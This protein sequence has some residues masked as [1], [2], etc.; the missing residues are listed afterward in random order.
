MEPSDLYARLEQII[1]DTFCLDAASIGPE[2]T[3]L[4]IDGWDSLSHLILMMNIEKSFGIKF[5]LEAV[6]SMRNVGD[7]VQLIS[8]IASGMAT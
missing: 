4:D 1:S 3:A 7:I 6:Y 5:P 8:E 2:T